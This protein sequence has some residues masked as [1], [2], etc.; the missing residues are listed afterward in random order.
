VLPNIS[1]SYYICQNCLDLV[2]K[3]YTEN[4]CLAHSCKLE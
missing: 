2:L 1:N 3:K 4:Y